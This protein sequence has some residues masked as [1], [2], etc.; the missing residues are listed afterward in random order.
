MRDGDGAGGDEGDVDDGDTPMK[1]A[2]PPFLAC[3]AVRRLAHRLSG[4]FPVRRQV[5]R[6]R[7]R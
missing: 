6:Q 1:T 3:V 7:D 2:V 5:E 4:I